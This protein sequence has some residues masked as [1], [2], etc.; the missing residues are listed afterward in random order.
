MQVQLSVLL[1]DEWNSSDQFP[2]FQ[3]VLMNSCPDTGHH[4]EESGSVLFT[5]SHLAFKHMDKI[6]LSF[7]FSRLNSPCSLSLSSQVRS[8]RAIIILG[9]LYWTSSGMSV[10]LLYW[11][12]PEL[13]L[14]LHVWPPQ[15]WVEGNDHLHWPAV[16]APDS[17]GGCWPTL[18]L[19]HVADSRT[20]LDLFWQ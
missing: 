14:V 15:C 6:S 1:W 17:P 5:P 16:N 4:Q 20:F 11:W 2:V 12:A 7:L 10:S 3:F 8:S 9:A 19:R 13:D 18:L